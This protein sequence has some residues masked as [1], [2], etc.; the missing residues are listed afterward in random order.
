MSLDQANW[1]LL[2][3]RTKRRLAFLA[4]PDESVASVS[5][6]RLPSCS[7]VVERLIRQGPARWFCSR[8]CIDAFQQQQRALDAAIKQ[9]AGECATGQHP[10]R[11]LARLRSDLE[12]LLEVRSAYA[13]PGAW[14]ETLNGC[15][16]PHSDDRDR[17]L[18]QRALNASARVGR[19]ACP[20][21]DGTGNGTQFFAGSSDSPAL[22]RQAATRSL[23]A[24]ARLLSGAMR[25]TSS[26]EVVEALD[27]LRQM[28]ID[29]ESS[30]QKRAR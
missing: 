27:A 24:V 17:D 29:S 22:K 8:A 5:T 1:P 2:D 9:L 7:A 21:C 23:A 10:A 12:W 13:V 19:Q 30:T 25:L 4:S 6:C 28:G 14:R 18:I 3:S 11:K 16:A 15:P 26:L 20:A